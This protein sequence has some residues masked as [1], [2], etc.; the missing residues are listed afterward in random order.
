VVEGDKTITLLFPRR[1]VVSSSSKARR[2]TKKVT[3]TAFLIKWNDS[4]SCVGVILLLFKHVNM[5]EF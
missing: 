1:C 2:K 3:T 4:F 5:N